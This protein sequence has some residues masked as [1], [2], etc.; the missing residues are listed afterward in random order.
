MSTALWLSMYQHM[1]P[2]RQLFVA[3]YFKT[4]SLMETLKGKR[5]TTRCLVAFFYYAQAST[6][7][8]RRNYVCHLVTARAAS[9]GGGRRLEAEKRITAFASFPFF[10]V[11]VLAAHVRGV[12][13]L[14][15]NPREMSLE[16]FFIIYYFF[17]Q[18][19]QIFTKVPGART[20]IGLAALAY[21]KTLTLLSLQ[22]TM[23]RRL[24][25]KCTN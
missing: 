16:V 14:E 11:P 17:L 3:A 24:I 18:F 1:T 13:T 20:V 21:V 12:H 4:I 25:T 6:L 23:F 2:A 22:I 9:A 5:Y 10:D 19:E 15:R 7:C 8:N